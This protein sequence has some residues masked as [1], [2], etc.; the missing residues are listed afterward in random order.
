MK[1]KLNISSF[2][3]I[4]TK[5]F[6]ILILFTGIIFIPTIYFVN[7]NAKLHWNIKFNLHQNENLLYPYISSV[8]DKIEEE[9]NLL[10]NKSIEKSELFNKTYFSELKEISKF[11]SYVVAQNLRNNNIQFSV[12]KNKLSDDFGS[13]V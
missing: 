11:S 1:N 5:H 10:Y 6:L 4:F 8:I 13:F 2:I 9:K 7:A 12:A 3:E